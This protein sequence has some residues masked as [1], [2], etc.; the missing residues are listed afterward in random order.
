MHTNT[1]E[2]N[3]LSPDENYKLF[4]SF[5]RY[6][7]FSCSPRALFFG[8]GLNSSSSYSKNLHLSRMKSSSSG[9]KNF[10]GNSEKFNFLSN[11]RNLSS[12]SLEKINNQSTS[13]INNESSLIDIKKTKATTKNNYTNLIPS[14]NNNISNN[15]YNNKY[16][17]ASSYLKSKSLYIGSVKRNLLDSLT[18]EIKSGTKNKKINKASIKKNISSNKKSGSKFNNNDASSNKK[19]EVD[20][21][22]DYL[23]KTTDTLDLEKMIDYIVSST[24]TY[25]RYN[26]NKENNN[27][28]NLNE[29][30][31][32]FCNSIETFDLKEKSNKKLNK[33][34]EEKEHQNNY[35][36]CKCKRVGC[37][38]YTCSCLKSGNKCN[39]CCGCV[40]CQNKEENNFLRINK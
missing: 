38:K 25:K 30:N 33:I 20:E 13:L 39:D 21:T 14:I 31:D 34:N 12:E 15:N 28:L 10:F 22:Y 32:N 40:N 24:K 26:E 5:Q 2:F 11:K 4:T 17:S 16:Q 1:P 29:N 35:S 3:S 7:N 37:I 9:A 8:M 18:K 6:G 36:I 23:S 19:S 27:Y